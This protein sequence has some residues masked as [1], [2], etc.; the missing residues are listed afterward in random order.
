MAWYI[1]PAMHHYRL[2]T[3][4]IPETGGVRQSSSAQF[5]PHYVNMPRITESDAITIVADDLLQALENPKILKQHINLTSK[6]YKVL[7]QLATIFNTASKEKLLK[8]QPPEM[9][10]FE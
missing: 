5:F 9:P 10:I 4:Y 6:H 8:L 1:G 3:F 7:K 2:F